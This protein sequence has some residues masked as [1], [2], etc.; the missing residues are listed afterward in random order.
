MAIIFSKKFLTMT[1][2]Y[3][4]PISWQGYFIWLKGKKYLFLLF[5]DKKDNSNLSGKEIL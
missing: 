2:C 5:G 1:L 3:T 4:K